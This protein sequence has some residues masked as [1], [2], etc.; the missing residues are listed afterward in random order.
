MS[1]TDGREYVVVWRKDRAG[2]YRE[3]SRYCYFGMAHKVALRLISEGHGAIVRC[4]ST[5]M[6][7]LS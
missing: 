1:L 3:W 7:G 4:P 5:A 6:G 2:E